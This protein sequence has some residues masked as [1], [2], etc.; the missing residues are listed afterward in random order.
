MPL[1]VWPCLSATTGVQPDMD[2]HILSSVSKAQTS[3]VTHFACCRGKSV[4]VRY[5]ELL[6]GHMGNALG[7]KVPADVYKKRERG[8]KKETPCRAKERGAALCLKEKCT[9][10]IPRRTLRP[11]LFSFMETRSGLRRERVQV[12]RH[13]TP[14]HTCMVTPALEEKPRCIHCHG[15]FSCRP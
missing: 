9:S 2:Q 7:A 12:C 13:G 14:S 5:A 15:I 1:Q 10:R 4:C 6:L 11:H 3:R 8:G